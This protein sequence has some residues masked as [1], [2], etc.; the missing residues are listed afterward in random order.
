MAA[1]LVRAAFYPIAG[2]APGAVVPGV[3][4]G[5]ARRQTWRGPGRAAPFWAAQTVVRSSP[6]E[7]QAGARVNHSEI[8]SF[9]WG[10]ADLIRDTLKRGKY[11]DV[12]LPLTVLRRLDCVLVA[13]KDRVLRRQAELHGKGLQDLD[14]QL[15]I[16]SGF[17]FYNTSRYDLDK[18]SR[19]RPSGGE[20]APLHLRL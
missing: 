13:T 15:R 6:T 19:T 17:A 8:V 14:Q 12:I 4:T 1:L 3:G 18:C 5:T 16:A 2:Q 11:Q 9:L 7:Q 10:V 20:P